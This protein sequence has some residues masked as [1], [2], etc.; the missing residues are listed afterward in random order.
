MTLFIRWHLDVQLEI[1]A[2]RA[3]FVFV[4]RENFMRKVQAKAS[5]EGIISVDMPVF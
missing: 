4:V 2:S 5:V 1:K 3:Y